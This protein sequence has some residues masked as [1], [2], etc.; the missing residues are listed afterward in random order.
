MT[1]ARAMYIAYNKKAIH[2]THNINYIV[3][4]HIANHVFYFF[5]NSIVYGIDSTIYR[6]RLP[7]CPRPMIT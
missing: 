1:I 7:F 4:Q 6:I 2:Y 3:T 5:D